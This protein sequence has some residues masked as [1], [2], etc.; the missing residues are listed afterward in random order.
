MF[1]NHQPLARQADLIVQTVAT[2]VLVFDKQT[3]RAYVLSPAAAAVW[4]ACNGKRSVREIADYL[5]QTSPTNE[6]TV[7]YALSQLEDL[8]QEPLLMPKTMVG[9][10]RRQFLKRAGLVAGAAAIPVVV[11]MVAPTAAH[12]QSVMEFCC[13]CNNT[14]TAGTVVADCAVCTGLC[15]ANGGVASCVVGGAACE[16]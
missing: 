15:V 3:D 8:L 2:E 14:P 7:W 6:Q 4:R 9:I 11:K 12:A 5:N 16:A 13:V 1:N 10:S